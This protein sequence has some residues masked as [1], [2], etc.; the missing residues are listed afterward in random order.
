LAQSED[1]GFGLGGFL[2][3]GDLFEG[4][5]DEGFEGEILLIGELGELLFEVLRDLDGS[6]GLGSW[7]GF[8]RL[9]IGLWDVRFMVGIRGSFGRFQKF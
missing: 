1:F 5:E 6:H 7:V 3:L 9:F 2:L 8:L 4:L